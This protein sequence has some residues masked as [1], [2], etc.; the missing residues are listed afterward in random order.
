MCGRY[1]FTRRL[2]ASRLVLPDDP[3]FVP[4]PRYNIAP[5]QLAP[6]TLLEDPARIR[7]LRWGLVPFWAKDP[8][9]G[10]SMIN[11]RSESLAEKPAFRSLLA[12][13]RCLAHADGF[14]EWQGA[15]KQKQAWRFCLSDGAPFVFAGLW[16]SW[17]SPQ[18]QALDSFTI[19]T[20]R[21]NALTA[22]I[23]DRMPVILSEAQAAIWMDPAASQPE[24]LALLEPYP[25][26]A[27]R[28]YPAS[29]RV[30]NVRNDDPEL[31]A[32]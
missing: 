7:F 17:R 32:E 4:G 19:I 9:I 2:D 24:C 31:I 10:A 21:P 12:R 3:A 6:V 13:G 5:T 16:S 11:A 14:Y 22:D 28:A 1:T 8:K 26:E 30:G 23:H 29:P 27:M 20:T 18:G 25:P 15:G